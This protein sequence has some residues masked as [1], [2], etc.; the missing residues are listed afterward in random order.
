M[1]FSSSA[2]VSTSL[3]SMKSTSSACSTS[4][5][6]KCPMRTLA[7]TGI[8]TVAMISR[9]TLM[10]AMRATPPSLRI[11]E[12]TRSSAI[13]AHAPA[14]SAI[15]AC[16]AFVTSMIT[17]PLSISAR[18]TFTRHSFDPFV[19]LLLPSAF[20]A[21]ISRLLSVLNFFVRLI[22]SGFVHQIF[23]H[24]R[25]AAALRSAHSALPLAH[26]NLQQLSQRG[27][28]ARDLLFIQAGEA[29]PQRVRQRRLH[30]EIPSRRKQHAAF[31]HVNE[32]GVLFA[33]GRYFYV[34]APLPN[35]LRLGFASL[36]EKQIARG[37]ATLGELL[38]IEMRKRQRGVRRAERSRVALV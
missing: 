22:F 32:R 30:V 20:F 35:T 5:S 29:Q 4:A 6:A 37:V 23:S 9:I 18:P 26:F 24:Q 13:T 12:G 38:K 31:F 2:G 15:L 19:P 21:S 8:V 25:H 28:A 11:S 34:Q 10:D 1:W 16:S 3:S 36:D 14:F 17:P 33:P 7:I 27:D